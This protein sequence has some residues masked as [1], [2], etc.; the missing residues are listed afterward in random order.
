L[1][2]IEIRHADPADIPPL[3]QNMREA[4]RREIWAASLAEPHAALARS[5]GRSE[6]AWTGLIDG[7]PAAMFGAGGP[8]S[9]IGGGASAWLLGTPEIAKIPRFFLT[10]SRVY[11]AMM[12]ERFPTLMNYVDVRNRA[13]LSWL[14]RLGAQFGAP[15]PYGALG[16]DFVPFTLRAGHV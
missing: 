1:V 8:L 15:Q 6:M 11:V 10:E 16:L 9:V 13:T 12:L 5:L 3:A 4:D 14:R 7:R 2:H